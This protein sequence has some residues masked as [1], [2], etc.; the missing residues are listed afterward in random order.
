[1]PYR[2]A[3]PTE[4]LRHRN[5]PSSSE[6]KAEDEPDSAPKPDAHLQY[7]HGTS[8]KDRAQTLL[9]DVL[10]LLP[11]LLLVCFLA[12]TGY[13]WYHSDRLYKEGYFHVKRK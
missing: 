13:L 2:P 7:R 6:P 10:L 5:A 3:A 1:M 8:L 12:Y 9:D 11:G 4:Q